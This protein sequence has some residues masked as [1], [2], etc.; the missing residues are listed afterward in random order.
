MPV[1]EKRILQEN[2]VLGI[3]EI[4]E[5]V[6]FLLS[7]LDLCP[8]EKALYNSFANDTRRKHWLSYRNLLKHLASKTKYTP[9]I[10]DENGKPHFVDDNNYLSV[11]HS[12]N[13]SAAIIS[14]DYPVGIDIEVINPRIEK[15]VNKFLSKAEQ[16][17]LNME[18][19]LEMLY[20]YWSAKEALYK[21]YG[22]GNLLFIENLPIE[23]FNYSP[24]GGKITGNILLENRKFQF[25]LHYQ[26]LQEYMLVYVVD[27]DNY[28]NL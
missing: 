8:E 13:V 23:P 19:R 14:S 5:E 15:V 18:Y 26:K 2:A 21:M 6:D 3:W 17:S 16:S 10:Y 11:S 28:L 1:L 27:A 7:A 12:G 9:L 20:V 22:K 25:T 24:S 4:K